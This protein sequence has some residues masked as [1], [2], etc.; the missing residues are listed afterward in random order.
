MWFSF[1]IIDVWLFL[2]NGFGFTGDLSYS[3]TTH[4]LH[5]RFW[6]CSHNCILWSIYRTSWKG[7]KRHLS[8]LLESSSFKFVNSVVRSV[9]WLI[10]WCRDTSVLQSF[11]FAESRP[12]CLTGSAAY[13]GA[14]YV[15]I[16]VLTSGYI[17]FFLL[18]LQTCRALWGRCRHNSCTSEKRE[19]LW[20]IPPQFAAADL[21]VW[22]LWVLGEGH[23][24][25]VKTQAPKHHTPVH[26]TVQQIQKSCFFL[27][28]LFSSNMCCVFFSV[29]AGRHWH[30]LVRR[31][32]RVTGC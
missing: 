30:Q 10:H 28:N 7:A 15:L 19:G 3:T 13:L 1:W 2:K 6:V 8:E 16:L 21:S 25:W 26:R 14:L 29:S 24:L 22:F 4:S 17:V 27:S 31:P 5:Q 23:H 20:E 12:R 11:M 9:L 32:L 18:F